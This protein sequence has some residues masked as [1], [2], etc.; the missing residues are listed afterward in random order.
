MQINSMLN[1]LKLIRPLN[2]LIIAAA[3]YLTLFCVILP[4]IKMSGAVMS[5]NHLDF[6]LF[7][8]AHVLLAAAGYAINDYYDTDVDAVNK[9]GKNVLIAR[10]HKR[11]AYNMNLVLN[12]IAGA[13]GFYCAYKA[14]SVKL[15]FLFVIIAL[16]LFYY[17]LKY[18]R[19]F[20]TGNLVVALL[21]AY[22][23]LVVWLFQFFIIKMHPDV[24]ASLIGSLG[25]I[26]IWVG[27]LALFAFLTTFI[28]ELVKDAEDYEGDSSAGYQTI[29][30]KLGIG[31][32]KKIIL[33]L[34]IFTMILLLC[35]QYLL[36]ETFSIVSLYLFVVQILFVYFLIKLVKAND[37]NH[38][39][40]LSVLAKLIIIAGLLATQVLYISQ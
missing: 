30:I 33:W 23:I 39:H 40:F 29:V 26:T 13:I 17:S 34:T 10:I 32:S 22:M 19:Q 2:L 37:K 14:G 16:L 24:F 8:F 31:I 36:F 12:I 3:Q 6:A 27:G 18:K 4:W 11:R 28:R 9:P 20:I 38:F 1:Y 35:T 25:T 15:G 7:V 5:V 21:G